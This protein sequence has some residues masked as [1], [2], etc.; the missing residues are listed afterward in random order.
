MTPPPVYTI[1][2]TLTDGFASGEAEH[3]WWGPT[4]CAPHHLLL[5]PKGRYSPS[6]KREV[7]GLDR[8]IT[9]ALAQVVG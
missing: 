3:R 1:H 2:M 4:T 6:A 8:R 5:G 9:L 7:V